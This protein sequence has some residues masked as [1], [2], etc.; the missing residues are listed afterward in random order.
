M[1]GWAKLGRGELLIT[2]GI[3]EMGEQSYGDGSVR[4]VC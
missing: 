2:E 3:K 4:K 1:V